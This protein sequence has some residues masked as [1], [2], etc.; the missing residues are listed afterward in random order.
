MTRRRALGAREEQGCIE[1][2]AGDKRGLPPCSDEDCFGPLHFAAGPCGPQ[3]LARP[4][5]RPRRLQGVG[6]EAQG[7]R[8][9]GEGED[10][11]GLAEARDA[12]C[13]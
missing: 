11:A 2:N 5:F 6:A 8:D 13:R 4:P 7:H 1:G 10:R 9:R 12:D 3:V